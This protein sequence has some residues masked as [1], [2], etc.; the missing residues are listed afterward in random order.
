METRDLQ[1]PQE[2]IAFL[3]GVGNSS[4][5]PQS[6]LKGTFGDRQRMLLSVDAGKLPGVRIEDHD[7]YGGWTAYLPDVAGEDKLPLLIGVY[8]ATVPRKEMEK[9]ALGGKAPLRYRTNR[10]GLYFHLSGMENQ[11][12]EMIEAGSEPSDVAAFVLDSLVRLITET[13]G[14]ALALHPGLPVLCSGGVM[15]CRKLAGEMKRRFG[16]FTASPDLS[17]DNALGIAILGY[18]ARKEGIG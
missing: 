8:N 12:S 18:L 9:L 14:D 7:E 15:S 16:A 11:F 3:R 13:T 6:Y 4:F 17:R 1:I 2:T 5:N 10:D